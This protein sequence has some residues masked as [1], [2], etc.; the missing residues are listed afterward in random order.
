MQFHSTPESTLN[1]KITKLA[2]IETAL[3]VALYVSIG[4]YFGTFRYLALAVLVAPLMLL[5]TQISG[6]WGLKIYM[7]YYGGLISK[8][9]PRGTLLFFTM[10]FL[11]TPFV[12]V[13]IRVIS[14]VYW[15]LRKP[16]FTLSEIPQNWLRQSFCIDFFTPQKSF[17]WK[18]LRESISSLHS[19]L[20]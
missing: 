5:R 3:S 7:R 10:A 1:L 17:R 14:T 11:A 15:A 12:G 16:L 20:L 4:L 19:P 18:Q 6:E 2:I 13:G 9:E 8:I